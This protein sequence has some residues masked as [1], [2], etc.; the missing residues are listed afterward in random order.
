L[1]GPKP[2]GF[3]ARI[4]AMLKFLQ[5]A[6]AQLVLWSAVGVA[7]LVLAFYLIGRFRP[8]GKRETASAS[9]LIAK[10]RDLH[11]QGQ[12]DDEEFRT[13]KTTLAAR[14]SEELKAAKEVK[15]DSNES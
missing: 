14:L 7:L 9:E 4:A 8:G 3:L 5:S 15:T 6:E 1:A 2:E 13:I 11:A 12:L 10:F